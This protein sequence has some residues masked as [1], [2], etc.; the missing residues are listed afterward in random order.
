VHNTVD[1]RQ[2]LWVA[3][4]RARKFVFVSHG[5][6]PVLFDHADFDAFRTGAS[7]ENLTSP[8]DTV[9]P[10]DHDDPTEDGVDSAPARTELTWEAMTA[11]DWFRLSKWARESDQLN[12]WERRFSYSQGVRESDSGEPTEKQALKANQIL[13]KAVEGGYQKDASASLETE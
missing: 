5:Q 11:K 13:A 12:G 1:D 3:L 4:T 6:L 8:P 9:V 7:L 2:A 10:N